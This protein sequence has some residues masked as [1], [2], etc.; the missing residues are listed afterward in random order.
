M[1]IIFILT[2]VGWQACCTSWIGLGKTVQVISF[3]ALL[4]ERGNK[5]PHLIVVPYVSAI[6]IYVSSFLDWYYRSS[7]LENWCR[8]FARFA[9]SVSVQVYYGGKNERVELRQTL[10]DT[11]RSM[12]GSE[13]DGWDVLITTY[14]LAQGDSDRKFFRRIEWDVCLLHCSSL[15]YSWS[16]QCC[17]FDEGHVLK[18]FQSQRYSSLLR[19]QSRWRLLLTGTPLQNNLQELV[20]RYHDFHNLQ[21]F[22]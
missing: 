7:T 18:N 15:M 5:G 10:L 3:L 12:S 14:N 1:K 17:V 22:S 19:V 16:I 9:S 13:D 6:A 20:V 21:V 11:R 2:S 8:E 4:R